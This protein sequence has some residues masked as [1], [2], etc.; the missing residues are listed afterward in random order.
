MPITFLRTTEYFCYSEP[1]FLLELIFRVGLQLSSL[2]LG[3][4]SRWQCGV[5]DEEEYVTLTNC[6]EERLDEGERERQRKRERD[7]LL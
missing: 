3:N 6:V 2:Y 5:H 7:A 4:N 1:L